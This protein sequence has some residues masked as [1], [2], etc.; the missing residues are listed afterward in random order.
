MQLSS[1]RLQKFPRAQ[2]KIE[3]IRPLAIAG[4]TALTTDKLGQITVGNTIGPRPIVIGNLVIGGKP[5]HSFNFKDL[6]TGGACVTA[7][8]TVLLQSDKVAAMP[9]KE[10]AG[11]LQKTPVFTLTGDSAHTL[12]TNLRDIANSTLGHYMV[13]GTS[14]GLVAVGVARWFRP[15]ASWGEVAIW[16]AAGAILVIGIVWLLAELGVGQFAGAKP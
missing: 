3:E 6:I 10:L 5:E 16:F 15:Q 2:A 13:V 4:G 9:V 8:G 1:T 7:A 12:A 14:G 11:V